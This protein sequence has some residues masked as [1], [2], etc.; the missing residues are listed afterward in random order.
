MHC[1]NCGSQVIRGDAFC[2]KCGAKLVWKE[3]KIEPKYKPPEHSNDSTPYKR[4]ISLT[5][6]ILFGGS[7]P[8][9]LLIDALAGG[10]FGAG[11]TILIYSGI[12]FV[13][14][15]VLLNKNRNFIR[16]YKAF[17]ITLGSAAGIFLL[18]IALIIISLVTTPRIDDSPRLA[19]EVV[20]TQEESQNSSPI[21]DEG[22]QK[23]SEEVTQEEKNEQIQQSGSKEN[24]WP[25]DK[26]I[27]VGEVGWQV[28]E[29]KDLGN[30]LKDPAGFFEDKKTSGK[31][32]FVRF[33]VKNLGSEMKT[34]TDLKIIDDQGREFT[35]YSE[36]YLYID[37]EETLFIL[38]NINPGISKIY[39]TIYEVP[40]DA[41]GIMLEVTSLEFAPHYAYISLGL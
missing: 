26:G 1:S 30:T 14:A 22:T 41:K 21:E 31:F 20:E 34:L 23:T 39:T 2:K 7:F 40:S 16:R 38:D 27:R 17:G 3:I 8:L 25:K 5:F 29:A 28:G 11:V 9:F 12:L 33:L 24:P 18:S 37:S 15:V 4:P 35:S 19:E 13:I 6:I 32:I 10:L 36:S